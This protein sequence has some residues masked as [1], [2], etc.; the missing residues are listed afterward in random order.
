MPNNVAVYCRV[1]TKEQG[2]SGLSLDS[3]RATCVAA[4]G[5][6]DWPIDRIVMEAASGKSVEK[7]PELRTLLEDL[8]AARLDGLV[9]ARLDRLA[10]NTADVYDLMGQAKDEG[11]TL[12]VLDPLVDLS[13]PFGRA[14]AGMAAVFAQLER[15]LIGQRQRESIA[16]R[17]RAGTYRGGGNNAPVYDPVVL[18]R[19]VGLYNAGATSYTMTEVLTDEGYTPPRATFWTP[20]NVRGIV[21][22]LRHGR[23]LIDGREPVLAD[24]R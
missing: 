5:E 9:V 11:W 2:Q 4:C 1:S 20:E 14:M 8:R 24:R 22:G 6:R 12:L 7:R 3:Q 19:I 18:K 15:E 23:I 16:A 13:T 10:R 17:K 21:A